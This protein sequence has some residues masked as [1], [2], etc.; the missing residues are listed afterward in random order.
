MKKIFTIILLAVLSLAA[1]AQE[2]KKVAI[3]ETVDK[4]GK[5]SYAHKLMLRSSLA[6]AI[7]E[8]YG[9]EAYD[10][11]DLASIMNEQEFQRTGNVRDDQIKQLG[12][13]T[14]AQYV[15]IAEAVMAGESSMFIT[16]KIIDVET[17]KTMKAETQLMNANPEDI[18]IGCTTMAGNMLGVKLNSGITKS[19][20]SSSQTPKPSSNQTPKSTTPQTN[21]IVKYSGV[22]NVGFKLKRCYLQGD[23]CFVHIAIT[24]NTKSD[25]QFDVFKYGVK[26]YD[27]NGGIYE[28]NGYQNDYQYAGSSLAG[29]TFGNDNSGYAHTT[30]PDDITVELKIMLKNF[31]TSASI[32]KTLQIELW[33]S[34]ESGHQKLELRNIPISKQ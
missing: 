9:W 7:T 22:A 16:A 33:N 17:A 32:I 15:L 27:D 28:G 8:A 24:N 2:T 1:F 11:V 30:I 25:L 20:S 10:R 18:Q 6:K 14:G 21:V 13:M 3:L 5:I 4:E 26:I 29:K 19:A 31:D 12:I 23:N 34:K